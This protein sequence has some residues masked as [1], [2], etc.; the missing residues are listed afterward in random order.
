MAS[1]RIDKRNSGPENV[2]NPFAAAL[3]SA[4]GVDAP[5]GPGESVLHDDED[6]IAPLTSKRVE[7]AT[8][9]TFDSLGDAETTEWAKRLKQ[10]LGVGGSVEADGQIL[11]QGDVRTKV[12]SLLTK[13]GWTVKRIGG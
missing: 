3:A 7:M 5:K 10:S 1:K 9:L 13:E 2:V 12:L 6:A 4:L 8:L 11:L